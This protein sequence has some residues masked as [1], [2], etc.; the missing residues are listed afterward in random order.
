MATRPRCVQLEPGQEGVHQRKMMKWHPR[1][2]PIQKSAE[3]VMLVDLARN[4]LGR[5]A[6]KGTIKVE[7]YDQ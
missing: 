2:L 7:P 3:H 1:C 4:D 6:E 5:V